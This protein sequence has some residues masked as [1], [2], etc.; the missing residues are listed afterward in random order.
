VPAAWSNVAVITA[1][2]SYPR[3]HAERGVV[4]IRF[5]QRVYMMIARDAAQT[6]KIAAIRHKRLPRFRWITG[7][8]V[9]PKGGYR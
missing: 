3:S 1:W 6:R 2:G 7:R 9:L 8:K 4:M 5:R